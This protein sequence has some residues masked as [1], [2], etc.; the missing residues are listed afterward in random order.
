MTYISANFPCRQ[1]LATIFAIICFLL[2]LPA[3]FAQVQLS[4]LTG[5]VRDQS[6]R[7]IPGAK[8]TAR[9]SSTGLERT[10]T[11]DNAGVYSLENLPPGAYLLSFAKGGFEEVRY[12]GVE[13]GVGQTR[14]IDPVLSAAGRRDEVTVSA[15]LVE[16]DKSSAALGGTIQSTAVQ[17]IPLN[18]RNWA[19]LT[20]LVP[21]AIDSGGSTQRTIRFVGRGRDDMFISYDG[22]DATGIANQAQKAYVRLSIP[23]E[24]IKEFRVDTAQYTAE[25]GDASGAQIV[26]ASPSGTNDF[27]GSLFEFLRN[28]FF[29]ARSPFDTTHSPL[30]FRLNQFGGSFSGPIWKNKTF[31]YLSYEGFRQVQDQTL[32]GFVPST[33]FRNQ[34]LAA[35]PVL[36]SI[37]NSFPAGSSAT[38]SPSIAQY[39]GVGGSLDNENSEMV[40][41]DHH[42][43][44]A[45]TAFIRFNY[46]QAIS[47]APLG[48]LTDRQRVY[49]APLNGVA[50]LTHI[51]SP[52]LLDDF[53][54]GINSAISRTHNLTNQPYSIAISGFTTLNSNTSSDQDGST[55]SWLD[56]ISWMHG[57][58]VIRAGVA[59]RRIQMNEGSAA[60]GTLTYSSL[61]NFQNNIL[62]QATETA[63][64][65]LKRMH[66]TQEAG[67]IQDEYKLKP[68]FTINAGLRYEYFSVFHEATGRA[69]PFDFAT[70]GGFCPAGSAFYF[71]TK[72]GFDPR[73]GLAWS[74]AAAHGN[75]VIRTG[76]GIYHEDGQ[77]D[78]EN[79]P[80]ANDV[81]NYTLTRGAAF[82]N[83]SYPIAPFLVNA[84]GVLSP[85]DL[86]R[87]RKDAYAQDWSFSLQQNLAGSFLGTL[88]Y[89][90][91]KGTNIMNRSYVNLINPLTGTRP[92]PQYGRIEFRD[93]ESN[94]SFNALQAS[95]QRSFAHGWLMA[96][97]YMWSHSINDA[98][99]GS[100]VEDDFPEN[101][102]CRACERA[103][104]DQ[105]ARHT[106]S[107]YT[108]YQLP[109]GAGR[110]YLSSPGF[111]RA[112]LGGWEW[113]AV[114]T[115]RSGLPINITVDRSSSALPDGNSNNQRP[116]YVSGVSL[117]PAGGSTPN[118]W[119]NPAAFA[120]PAAGT[121]G[122]LGRNA[123]NGPPLWQ[124]DTALAKQVPLTER[125][126][127]QFRAECFNLLN[128]A[129]Y[130][131]PLADI[132]VPATFG[133]ITSLVN[134][135]PT[136]SGTPRQFQLSLRL[137]F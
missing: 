17:E 50:E 118:L 115:G 100:G 80:T 112:I 48:T 55:F 133:R 59:I 7:A 15:P 76:Y 87:N 114:A 120:V 4:A 126:N 32:I 117:V 6:G 66:K 90:G 94:S 131:N 37:L 51:F 64:M 12:E 81:A 104:S 67:Y 60:T 71:P 57:K 30:P 128:R 111:T 113:N 98:S 97:N 29:D 21:G 101:V 42:F 124:I 36:A 10:T 16:L 107:A 109:F 62:D 54:F 102:S 78:D 134:T 24:A 18:G 56:N 116:N 85:K 13:Q 19:S 11:S 20:A 9:H 132:S 77:L 95:T 89:V 49:T 83:L 127:L 99:L 69:A 105:D 25:Y 123:F 74:P 136:G 110:S 88:A 52:T 38:S 31:F 5:T 41:V 108:V 61:A 73:V 27:H 8:V 79:F 14:T 82:P 2:F 47:V 72:G 39:T 121:W 45:T 65:P 3:S 96:A 40:R 106:F 22:V 63:L 135:T 84:T 137:Q 125:A 26:V 53:S 103:S 33:S 75:T 70:C 122:N 35:S 34:V 130:G 86:A 43:T 28:S 129:Q 44:D 46:D 91:S 23:T 93:N 1:S 119:I 68:N 58:H 92:Y